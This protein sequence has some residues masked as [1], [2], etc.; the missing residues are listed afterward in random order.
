MQTEVF[1]TRAV[2]LRDN[3]DSIVNGLIAAQKAHVKCNNHF[4]LT[5]CIIEWR[6]PLTLEGRSIRPTG[7]TARLFWLSHELDVRICPRGKWITQKTQGLREGRR[8]L[9]DWIKLFLEA[10]LQRHDVEEPGDRSTRLSA[11]LWWKIRGFIAY[12]KGNPLSTTDIRDD[13]ASSSG[14]P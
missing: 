12:E 14:G 4:L 3:N 5:T 7:R 9:S 1:R 11:I 10:R 2:A 13:A 6:S 8:L